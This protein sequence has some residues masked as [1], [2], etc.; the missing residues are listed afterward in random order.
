[1]LRV[2]PNTTHSD[3]QYETE[4]LSMGIGN[5]ALSP[6]GRKLYSEPNISDHG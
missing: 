5:R 3:G 1:M 6:G 4:E 2:L